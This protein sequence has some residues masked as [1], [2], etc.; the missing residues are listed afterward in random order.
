M[1]EQHPPTANAEPKVLLTVTAELTLRVFDM[2]D[3]CEM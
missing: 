3:M 1:T 2:H